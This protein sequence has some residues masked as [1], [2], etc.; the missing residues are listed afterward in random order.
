MQLGLVVYPG[1][2]QFINMQV[3]ARVLH[4]ACALIDVPSNKL[5]SLFDDVFIS[6][7]ENIVHFSM[8]WDCRSD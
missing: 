7:L 8:D 4:V 5:L 6:V 1:D 3:L 2:F